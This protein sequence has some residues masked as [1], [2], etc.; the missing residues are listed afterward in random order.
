MLQATHNIDKDYE[1]VVAGVSLVDK[2][3]YDQIMGSYPKVSIILDNPTAV[4]QQS[5][6][7]LVASGTATLETAFH[8]IPQ[9]VCYKGHP[10]SVWLGKKLV[11]LKYISLVNIILNQCLIPERIQ[12]KCTPEILSKDIRKLSED[13][14]VRDKI[15]QG[16]E[17]LHDMF[18]DDAADLAA[19]AVIEPLK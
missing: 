1:I 4:I 13:S 10:V 5:K 2:S 11:K 8:G 17:R 7:A 9:V 15:I 16:Y 14:A 3:V 18:P 12:D 6:V 19:Q